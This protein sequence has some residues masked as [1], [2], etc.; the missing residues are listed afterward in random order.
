MSCEED[1]RREISR[2]EDRQGSESVVKLWIPSSQRVPKRA[3]A[4]NE[5]NDVLSAFRVAGILSPQWNRWIATS[6]AYLAP[7]GACR[8]D[9][10]AANPEG[11]KL[12]DAVVSRRSRSA[13]PIIPQLHGEAGWIRILD[14]ER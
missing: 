12:P 7:Q 1:T 2:R 3:S 14:R 13:Y 4:I 11:R 6:G 10:A 5:A 9:I 8:A